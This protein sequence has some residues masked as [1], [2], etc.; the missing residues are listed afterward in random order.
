MSKFHQ[1]LI[2]FW[3]THI[4]LKLSLQ[5]GVLQDLYFSIDFLFDILILLSCRNRHS[6]FIFLTFQKYLSYRID[7]NNHKF[8][9]ILS[10]FQ[11]SMVLL[12]SFYI[13]S[14]HLQICQSFNMDFSC[15]KKF[16][17]RMMKT[18][19]KNLVAYMLL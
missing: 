9:W 6:D 2:S 3:E 16:F 5:L 10:S 7:K 18:N 12:W 4:H 11:S 19:Q 8:F 13:S 14:K 1:Y 15:Y 17:I